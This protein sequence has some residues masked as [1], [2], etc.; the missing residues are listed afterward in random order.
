VDDRS[1]EIDSFFEREMPGNETAPLF[2]EAQRLGIGFYLGFAEIEQ[3]RERRA[4]LQTLDPR[5]RQ[6]K[7]A[8]KYRKIHLP[9]T[10]RMNPGAPSSIWRSATSRSAIS[11]GASGRRSVEISACA[12]AMTGAGRRPTGSWGCR[13]WKWSCSD[14]T[15]RATTRRTGHDALSDFHNQLSMQAE[16]RQRHLGGRVWPRPVSRRA[17]S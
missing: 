9:V 7:V 3:A 11:V 10:P 12:S 4:S 17:A 16:L 8:G 14:T 1:G 15:R 5:G 2:N 13:M 6:R